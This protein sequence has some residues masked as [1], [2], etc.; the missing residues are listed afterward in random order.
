MA[1]SMSLT[2]EFMIFTVPAHHV[3]VPMSVASLGTPTIN[4]VNTKWNIWYP[5]VELESC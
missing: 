3:S 4:T 1:S 2:A 5:M